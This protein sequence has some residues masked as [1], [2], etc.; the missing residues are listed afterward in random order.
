MIEIDELL[1]LFLFND[2]PI[3]VC[4]AFFFVFFLFFLSVSFVSTEECATITNHVRND[5]ETEEV[6]VPKKSRA[7]LCC[8]STD[9][10]RRVFIVWLFKQ[11]GAVLY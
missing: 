6:V 1:V 2:L 4:P 8:P 3:Y 5:D 10:E 7:I 9:R 11:T